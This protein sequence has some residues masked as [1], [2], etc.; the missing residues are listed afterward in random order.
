MEIIFVIFISSWLIF[1]GKVMN[2]F[3]FRFLC[4]LVFVTILVFSGRRFAGL[5]NATSAQAMIQLIPVASGLSSPLYVTS[6]RDGSNRLFIVEQT[7]SVKVLTPGAAAP[8]QTPFLNIAVKIVAGG[9]QGLLG[10]AFHP[11]Y[12]SNRRFFVNYT[13]KSDGAT[14]VS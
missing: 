6:A 12:A 7:G 3:T 8:L 5:N 13:R 4:I 9:E 14:V 11:Q 2:K 1:R 10:L